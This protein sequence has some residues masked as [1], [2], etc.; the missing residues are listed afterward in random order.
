MPIDLLHQLE[1]ALKLQKIV[2]LPPEFSKLFFLI[3]HHFKYY[4]VAGLEN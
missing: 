2:V 3:P 4:A 1:A